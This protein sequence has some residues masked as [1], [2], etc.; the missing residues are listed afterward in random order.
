MIE[1][2]IVQPTTE[3]AASLPTRRW[4]GLAGLAGA[5]LLGT[6]FGILPQPP[7][8]TVPLGQLVD[9]ANHNHNLLLWAAWMEAAGSALFVLF[10]VSLANMDPRASSTARLLTLLFGGAVVAVGLVYAI[11]VIAIAQTAALGGTQLATTAVAYGL[12]AACEHAFVL[13]P[14]VFL[15]LGFALRGSS[16]LSARFSNTAIALGCAEVVLGLV[17]LFYAGPNN[18]GA[19]GIAINVLIGLQGIWAIVAAVSLQR[20]E[21][22][23]TARLE[24][25]A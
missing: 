6:S 4:T 3:H 25:P 17:G 5:V 20:N 7:A 15:P 14:P 18:A 8:V 11:T 22:V 21:T 16:V 19:V 9:Y 12:F 24:Q 10:L 13:A 2:R 1:H 23:A